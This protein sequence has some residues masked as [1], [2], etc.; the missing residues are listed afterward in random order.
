MFDV[1]ILLNRWQAFPDLADL[2]VS[3]SMPSLRIHASEHQVQH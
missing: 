2:V 3:A 1:P